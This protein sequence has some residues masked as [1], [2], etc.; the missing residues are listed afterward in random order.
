M[1]K[2]LLYD[3]LLNA[4]REKIP[5]RT[6]LVNTLVD[7][8][9]I[10]K[11][12]VYR[13]LRGEVAFTFAEIVTIA[14][15]FGISLDNLIGTVTA[16][17]RPFQLK[18]VDFV[19][20]VDIDYDMLEQYIDILCMAREDEQSELIDC[21][22]ILPQQLYMKYKYISRFY[23]FKWMYQCG[24][25]GKSKRF[26]DI[27]VTERFEE[28]Q[29]ASVEKSRYIRNS[30]YILDP[31]VFHYL[32]N[33][34]NYFMSIHLITAEEVKLLKE[35]LQ[36]LLNE[37]EVLATRGYFEE[38]GNKVFLYISSVNFDTSYWC[39]QIKN[40]HI[41]MIKT[42]ILSSVASLDESTYDKL[43]KWLR[44][45][46]RSSIMISVSGERQRILFFEK[47]REL[48]QSL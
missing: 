5:Q 32:V 9:C 24:S 11:E 40:Y 18:L 14:N 34:I 31:L 10:E 29:L 27:D 48:I 41:S 3:N 2:D 1:K 33:D 46:I 20:P 30:Y 38:T 28:M 44:A 47:Q 6:V 19:N 39:V 12:A 8:L 23:L 25:P 21:T 37:M 26:Q 17:S 43:R 35:E 22:N 42:F 7:L 45:L 13:R 36:R 4:V 16:K 15:E